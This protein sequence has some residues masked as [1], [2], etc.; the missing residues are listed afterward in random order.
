M[1][2]QNSFYKDEKKQLNVRPDQELSM[3]DKGDD[4]QRRLRYQ[5][6]YIASKA[7]SMLDATSEVDSLFCEHHEDILIK[8]K[9]GG[10]VGIQVKTRIPNRRPITAVDTD[11]LSTMAR[12]IELDRT[13][14]NQF[15]RFVIASNHGFLSEQNGRSLDFLVNEAA[16]SENP[17]KQL[18]TYISKINGDAHSFS[19]EDLK[20]VLAKLEL[21]QAL[22]QFQ[23]FE[24]II[25]EQIRQKGGYIATKAK[26]AATILINKIQSMS[27]LEVPRLIECIF[28]INPDEYETQEIIA[29]KKL[30]PDVVQASLLSS[31]SPQQIAI[32]SSLIPH[33]PAT[34]LPPEVLEKTKAN[35]KKHSQKLLHWPSTL[36][37]S[38][39]LESPCLEILE[40]NISD[41]PS[42]I[43]LVLGAPGAGKSALLAILA[44][45]MVQ[46]QS[47]VLALK[48]D[49]L[50]A[51][52]DT[53][54][55]IQTTLNLDAPLDV[56]IQELSKTNKII[57]ILDQLDALSEL[58]CLYPQRIVIWLD[59]IQKLAGIKNVHIVAST[60][61]F[62]AEH[63]PHLRSLE[64]PRVYL[65]LPEWEQIT[66]V[67]DGRQIVYHGWPEDVRTLLRTPQYLK[68]FLDIQALEPGNVFKSYRGLLN[69]LWRLRVED[70]N[71]TNESVLEQIAEYM[72]RFEQLSAP[73]SIYSAN[74]TAIDCLIRSNILQEDIANGTIFFTHQTLFEYVRART[75][76]KGTQSLSTYVN[77]R[78]DSLFI[79]PQL[80]NALNY[81]R[82]GSD[83]QY[84]TEVS[85]LINNPDL[86]FHLRLLIIEFLGQLTEPRDYEMA[87]LLPFLNNEEI[88]STVLV[89]VAGSPGWFQ[90]LRGAFLPGFMRRSKE[91]GDEILGLLKRAAHFD[92]ETVLTLLEQNWLINPEM[93]FHTLPILESLPS[94]CNRSLNIACTILERTDVSL[95]WIER[96]TL[97]KSNFPGEL[98][99]KLLYALLNGELKRARNISL[100]NHNE[101]KAEAEAESEI[102]D[103]QKDYNCPHRKSLIQLIDRDDFHI[104]SDLINSDP[105][106][107]AETLWPWL[108]DLL[109]EIA[110]KPH[111]FVNKYQT[112][113]TH[114][115]LDEPYRY[116]IVNA[117]DDALSQFAETSPTIYCE[118][119]ERNK[120]IKVLTLQ[121]LLARG[122]LKTVSTNPTV[123]LQF[124][125]EDSRRL[126]LGTAFAEHIDSSRL[127]GALYP[128]LD[129]EQ[130]EILNKHIKSYSHYT[131][132]FPDDLTTTKF[133]RL[134]WDRQHRLKLLQSVPS[135]LASVD[136]NKLREEEERAFPDLQNEREHFKEVS[137][138]GSPIS[139]DQMNQASVEN[140]LG[141]FRELNDSTGDTHPKDAMKGGTIQLSHNLVD[142]AKKDQKKVF[143]L[144][145]KF[146]PNLNQIAAS[147]AL[148]GLE[149]SGL[150][151][152]SLFQLIIN[153]EQRGFTSTRVRSRSASIVRNKSKAKIKIPDE[154]EKLLHLFLQEHKG[155]EAELLVKREQREQNSLLWSTDVEEGFSE[156]STFTFIDAIAAIYINNDPP[157][158]NE[159]LLLLE[160]FLERKDLTDYIST[161]RLLAL[162][163]LTKL[164]FVDHSRANQLLETLLEN[165]PSPLISK[166]GIH[167]FAYTHGWISE[168]LV[169]LWLKGFRDSSWSD[170]KQA[171][172]E[173]LALHYM[174]FPSRLWTKTAL[175]NLLSNNGYSDSLKGVAYVIGRFWSS[176][177][178]RERKTNLFSAIL[179]KDDESY[180]RAI[181]K[182]LL[183]HPLLVD[184]QTKSFLD[185]AACKRKL[186]RTLDT[187]RFLEDLQ[188]LVAWY[189][190][191]VYRICLVLI[192]EFGK[193]IGDYRT[194]HALLSGE[195]I[196]LA[197]HLQHQDEPARSWGLDLFERL[198]RLRIPDARAMLNLLDRRVDIPTSAPPPRL[199]RSRKRPGRNSN[200]GTNQ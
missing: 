159:W 188:D 85:L 167:L 180:Y 8:L 117:L 29:A 100:P 44:N 66:P 181:S 50:L 4:M 64:A 94:W 96:L 37:G 86:R 107:F 82:D 53:E 166:S 40:K 47:V 191:S 105:K 75:F 163:W 199:R 133:Q 147:H 182:G 151:T 197:L 84:K 135:D 138:I 24:I 149:Q 154:I 98:A 136:F 141:L 6:K 58:T 128:Y 32:P 87:W 67:L 115:D 45:N 48:I 157:Q 22:P 134:K 123:S 26:E 156:T 164:C 116:S 52:I 10:F 12:F 109:S 144:I 78:Q 60:R 192:E 49:Q 83:G 62:E 176:P 196:D 195:L 131:D 185:S 102:Q 101:V 35:F 145:E 137:W 38:T 111:K 68:I 168:E 5:A 124:L 118:F 119:V 13:Y 189:P 17:T 121:R 150:D 95:V 2:P 143:R 28:K 3:T 71:E 7:I 132:H 179:E 169:R 125:I 194:S 89:S 112:D 184:E 16:K 186:L 74:R 170:G 103:L 11:I 70:S 77:S 153:L 51:N 130:R 92:R 54:L 55:A 140:L 148:A 162:L 126:Y 174:W 9:R 193:D 56:S 19:I 152:S 43:Q 198:I 177:G 57:V 14:R 65:P 15:Q 63:D 31:L 34:A 106:A 18:T 113:G 41:S 171:Y 91:H 97:N 76:L 175:D 90:K 155:G 178:D 81:M 187:Y 1:Y 39:R 30:T 183:L 142:L 129:T 161:W 25:A 104:P 80:W 42:S 88:R 200:A 120:E 79:R 36:D 27:S 46:A 99:A 122:L 127:I 172:G 160:E 69:T 110:H 165:Q 73:A 173:L 146:D 108:V 114:T 21:E 23:D 190:E 139:I 72:S 93:D 61:Q 59:L 158:L 33:I 20:R